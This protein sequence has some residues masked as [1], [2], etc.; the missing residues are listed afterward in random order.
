ML[1]GL[2]RVKSHR[3][4][5]VPD[6]VIWGLPSMGEMHFLTVEKIDGV[7]SVLYGSAAIAPVQQEISFDQ[8]ID[9]RGN[10]LPA[11]IDTPRVMVRAR[12]KPAVFIV[13]Q[14]SNESFR[15]ARDEDA[16]GPV[17][18]DLMILEMGG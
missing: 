10:Q 1:T 6:V 11:S 9:H 3:I 18:A 4:W 8:L 14:E 13:G 5:F 2:E 12:A 7:S 15:I 17:T 16:P